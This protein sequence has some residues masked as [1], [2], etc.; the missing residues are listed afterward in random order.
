[1]MKFIIPYPFNC[2]SLQRNQFSCNQ[3][4]YCN[5]LFNGI[6]LVEDFFEALFFTSAVLV[7]SSTT[8]TKIMRKTTNFTGK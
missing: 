5:E 8:W 4:I 1:M 3:K 6:L 7:A 2:C